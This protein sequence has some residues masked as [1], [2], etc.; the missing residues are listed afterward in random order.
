[1]QQTLALV[2]KHFAQRP[3]LSRRDQTCLLA[4]KLLHSGQYFCTA[5]KLYFHNPKLQHSD[6]LFLLATKVLPVDQTILF[7][8]QSLQ[9]LC[10]PT[11]LCFWRPKSLYNQQSFCTATKLIFCYQTSYSATKTLVFLC[12]GAQCNLCQRGDLKSCSAKRWGG[13][14]CQIDRCDESQM[15]PP[16]PK[17]FFIL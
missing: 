10:Y 4:T 17:I 6:Q 8:D 12:S 5:I 7:S 16:P 13:D 15:T 11:K 3:K 14:S 2:S 9:K 1:M